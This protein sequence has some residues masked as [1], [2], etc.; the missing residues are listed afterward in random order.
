[1][2]NSKLTYQQLLESVEKLEQ[3]NNELKSDKQRS[4]KII[5]GLKNGN[6][7]SE[8]Q[9]IEQILEFNQK[10]RRRCCIRPGG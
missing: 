3:E 1:M 7:I 9:D 10:R 8:Q 5:E 6:S 4:E 2:K